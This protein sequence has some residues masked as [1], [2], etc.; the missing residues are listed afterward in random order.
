M[1]G[2]EQKNLTDTLKVIAWECLGQLPNIADSKRER[3]KLQRIRIQKF[4]LMSRKERDYNSS[5]GGFSSA[6]HKLT[7]P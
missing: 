1:G 7:R 4:V 3:K 5:R 6:P 2:I